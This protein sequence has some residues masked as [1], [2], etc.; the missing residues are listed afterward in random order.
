[1]TDENN[2]FPVNSQGLFIVENHPIVIALN[3]REKQNAYL[4]NYRK[5]DKYKAHV[6]EYQSRP[7]T[8]I[9]MQGYQKKYNLTDKGKARW[10]VFNKT[11]KRI[12]YNKEYLARPEVKIMR[13]ATYARNRAKPERKAYLATWVQG[14]KRQAWNSQYNRLPEVKAKKKAYI[15]NRLKTDPHFY[16]SVL[17]RNRYVRIK[18]IA[19]DPNIKSNYRAVADYLGLPP[20]DGRKYQR[21]HIIPLYAFN[22]KDPAQRK[23]ALAP[24]NHQWLTVEEHRR[25]TVADRKKYKNLSYGKK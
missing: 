21:D 5:S 8:K 25:K 24:E 17:I 20:N 15:S 9:L 13:K 19:A 14:E 18:K 4:R 16:N 7:H 11:Q 3:K 2:L 22:L 23:I 6:K 10:S 1:M 12:N